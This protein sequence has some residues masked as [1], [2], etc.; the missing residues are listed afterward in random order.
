MEAGET[1]A[2][3]TKAKGGRPSRS[4]PELVILTVKLE[5]ALVERLEQHTTRL[6]TERPALNVSRSAAVRELLLDA[7]VRAEQTV[8]KGAP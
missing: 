2:T 6:R 3:M 5:P 7:L 4:G 1:R 8:G